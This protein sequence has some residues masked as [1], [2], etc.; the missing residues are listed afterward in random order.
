MAWF[1]MGDKVTRRYLTRE[2]SGTII[3]IKF[4][5]EPHARTYTV[6]LDAPVVVSESAH[7]KYERRRILVHLDEAGQS[8]DTKNRPDTIA[9]L[10]KAP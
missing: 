5:R 7:M 6:K 1:E 9:R 2:V 3:D 10:A 8:L 4:D